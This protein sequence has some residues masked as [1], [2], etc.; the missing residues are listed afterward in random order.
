MPTNKAVLEES[1]DEK[2]TCVRRVWLTPEGTLRL[3]GQDIGPFVQQ[4]FGYPEYE[5]VRAVSASGV[6]QL[7]RA[8]NLGAEDDLIDA[9]VAQFQGPGG[10]ARLEKFLET[11][12]IESEFWNRIGD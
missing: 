2:G 7:R 5:F 11:Q 8:L 3:E 10:S 9:L 6:E 4:F 12:G 1:N